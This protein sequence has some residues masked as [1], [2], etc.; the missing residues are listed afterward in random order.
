MKN[1]KFLTFLMVFPLLTFLTVVNG[2]CPEKG[3]PVL[4]T[5]A[6]VD[7]FLIIYP[8]CEYIQGSLAIN[9]VRVYWVK[10]EPWKYLMALCGILIVIFALCYD[11]SLRW[12]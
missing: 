12:S 1:K 5:Q 8:D 9:N 6:M 7:S 11:M 2:Q 10:E 3:K 4:E